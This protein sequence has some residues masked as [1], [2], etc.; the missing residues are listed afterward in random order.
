MSQPKRVAHW[1]LTAA[2]RHKRRTLFQPF[3]SYQPARQ[4]STTQERA[5][6]EC[7][8]C[9]Q[10]FRERIA[11][12]MPTHG[13]LPEVVIREAAGL[14]WVPWPT[15]LGLLDEVRGGTL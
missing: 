4:R 7:S 12:V 13:Y 1:R 14:S 3:T 11:E 6:C 10:A 8:I 15:F 2:V 9:R 5:C